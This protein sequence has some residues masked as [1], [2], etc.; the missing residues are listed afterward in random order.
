MSE[1]EAEKN[2]EFNFE[3]K[4]I[5]IN[6]LSKNDLLEKANQ[7]PIA[8]PTETVYGLSAPAC[9]SSVIDLI[10]TVKKRPKNNPLILHVNDKEFND[11]LE[12]KICW[13]NFC[14]QNVDFFI[15]NDE[16][17]ENQEFKKGDDK[18]ENKKNNECLYLQNKV[19]KKH[20]I[21]N[22]INRKLIETFWPGP[23][24]LIFNRGNKDKMNIQVLNKEN[25]TNNFLAIRSPNYHIT[26][27]Y[28]SIVGP[29]F[30][31]SANLSG[32]VSCT[33]A[34]HVKNDLNNR[35]EIIINS[36]QDLENKSYGLESTI[37]SAY[38][39]KILR[40]GSISKEDI[41][42]AIEP[43]LLQMKNL[44]FQFEDENKIISPGT[45]H[46]HY[47]PDV[48]FFIFNQ[49]EEI[50]KDIKGICGIII[51]DLKLIENLKK[52]IFCIKYNEYVKNIEFNKKDNMI[53]YYDIGSTKELQQRNFFNS[54][55]CLE[56]YCDRIFMMKSQDEAIW[57]RSKR[58]AGYVTNFKSEYL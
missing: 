9:N 16:I 46:K 30:A 10:F 3:T 12:Y 17:Y 19:P 21:A 52:N 49:L 2:I 22:I 4:I 14:D 58:A 39:N 38:T 28:I 8:I 45:V 1:K 23:L 54:L 37:Y 5:D 47:V 13:C 25:K 50:Q 36:D 31:P 48:P 6:F 32:K 20:I 42:K 43:I 24:T 33:D 11:F 26:R 41:M 53:I 55:K 56:K 57:D 7:H 40:P 27:Q 18:I 15:K 35:I 44:K 51:T 34:Q 29:I